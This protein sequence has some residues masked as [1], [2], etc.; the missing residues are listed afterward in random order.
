MACT[1]ASGFCAAG[2]YPV[3][4]GSISPPGISVD[5][6]RQ[7]DTH[8]SQSKITHTALSDYQRRSEHWKSPWLFLWV[9]SGLKWVKASH[10]N[11]SLLGPPSWVRINKELFQCTGSGEPLFRHSPLS[12]ILALNPQQL[13][14]HFS[15]G[16]GRGP[17]DGNCSSLLAWE[18]RTV[19]FTCSCQQVYYG[20]ELWGVYPGLTRVHPEPMAAVMY[21]PSSLIREAQESHNS[22]CMDSF[23]SKIH[24][25]LEFSW[26]F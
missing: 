17:L 1:T 20:L 13:S 24:A 9:N 19:M 22:F 6:C 21:R 12:P 4:G 18:N 23:A 11:S 7:M 3:T 14:W 2:R 5:P 8:S 16:V 15:T 26:I 10:Y 25:V